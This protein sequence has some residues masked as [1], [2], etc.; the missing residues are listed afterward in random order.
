MCVLLISAISFLFCGFF[1][2]ALTAQHSRLPARPV[3]AYVIRERKERRRDLVGFFPP[4]PPHDADDDSYYST[5][6]DVGDVGSM[7]PCLP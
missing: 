7:S 6:R 1:T 3:C 4:S 5:R 2:R